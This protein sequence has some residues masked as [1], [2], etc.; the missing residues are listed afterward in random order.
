MVINHRFSV[1]HIRVM[2]HFDKRWLIWFE[3]LKVVQ[4]PNGET[5]LSGC[6]DQSALYGYLNRIHDLGLE[7]I[8]VQKKRNKE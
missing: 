5:E 4:Y 8:S 6:M 2:G 7:V 3:E 1:Y